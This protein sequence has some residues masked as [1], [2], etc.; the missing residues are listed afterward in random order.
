MASYSKEIVQSETIPADRTSQIHEDSITALPVAQQPK[1]EPDSA[2]TT[3]DGLRAY[4]P[5]ILSPIPEDVMKLREAY[6]RASAESVAKPNGFKGRMKS[7]KKKVLRK[8]R[9]KPARVAKVPRDQDIEGPMLNDLP[10]TVTQRKP[11]RLSRSK[12][13]TADV[14]SGLAGE[15]YSSTTDRVPTPFTPTDSP[16]RS[17]KG[18][19]SL[20][21][22]PESH[23]SPI[24]FNTLATFDDPFVLTSTPEHTAGL[25]N[26]KAPARDSER[27]ENQSQHSSRAN[28]RNKKLLTFLLSQSQDE[29]EHAISKGIYR[30][31]RRDALDAQVQAMKYQVTTLRN[32]IT[33]LEEQIEAKE[34]EARILAEEQEFEDG[35]E[36]RRLERRFFLEGMVGSV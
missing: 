8:F 23:G 36:E 31:R 13:P 22:I 3:H 34:V 11:S 1:H 14:P 25:S 15:A 27:P 19:K 18:D 10:N 24:S 30:R 16:T 9:P 28:T 2:T 4:A 6:R 7:M 32:Q 26:P 35:V 17:F 33:A 12:A 21:P 20:P 5:N 29:T